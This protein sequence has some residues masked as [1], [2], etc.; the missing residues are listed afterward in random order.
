MVFKPGFEGAF[1]Q[2]IWC[3]F[4]RYHQKR[5]PVYHWPIPWWDQATWESQKSFIQSLRHR[6]AFVPWPYAAHAQQNHMQ[7]TS[8]NHGLHSKVHD[9]IMYLLLYLMMVNSSKGFARIWGGALSPNR[10]LG[11]VSPYKFRLDTA[12]PSPS[13]DSD[14]A[15]SGHLRIGPDVNLSAKMCENCR[16]ESI[17][18]HVDHLSR[19]IFHRQWL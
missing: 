11:Q 17:W 10:P 2:Q 3:V 7:K 18:D 8:K 13:N 9:V 6:A 12:P 16:T 15:D 4:P 1:Q 14:Q 19:F 5:L